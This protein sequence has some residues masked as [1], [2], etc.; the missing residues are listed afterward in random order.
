MLRSKFENMDADKDV[1]LELSPRI[2]ANEGQGKIS[3]SDLATT[4][5]RLGFADVPRVR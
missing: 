3:A 5:L 4:M 1:R 2:G